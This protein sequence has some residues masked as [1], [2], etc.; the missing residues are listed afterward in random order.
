MESRR[1]SGKRVLAIDPGGRRVGLA[2]SD[3]LGITAQGLDTFETRGMDDLL[4]HLGALVAELGVGV[5][6]VGEPRSLA[7]GDIEG[8]G[9][10]RELAAAIRGRLPVAVV[11]VDERMTSREAERV[12]AA[13]ERRHNRKDIDRLAAV[14]L[15]QGFLDGRSG[16]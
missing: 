13:G 4:D 5:V 2:V 9:R 8:T 7:G 6:V 11:L 10:S 1:E 14:L 16:R 3:E 15:L 12:L